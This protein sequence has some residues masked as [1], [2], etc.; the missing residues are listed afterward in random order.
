[1]CFQILNNE[2]NGTENTETGETKEV[3]PVNASAHCM[4]RMSR[5]QHKEGV[6]K[7]TPV[8]SLY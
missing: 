2:W 7:W 5:P 6:R 8:V 4:E 3:N 1:M